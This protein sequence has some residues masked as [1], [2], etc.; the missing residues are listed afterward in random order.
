MQVAAARALASDEGEEWVRIARKQYQKAA[1]MTAQALRMAPPESGTFVFFDTRPVLRGGER[2]HA[3][4]ER[5]AH[6]GVVLTPGSVAG[7]D[8]ADWARL[9]FTA[10]P[11]PRLERALATLERVLYA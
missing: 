11:L 1:Q 10:V 8:Y 7:R 5:I 4:L 3:L 6:S 2:P 9:C